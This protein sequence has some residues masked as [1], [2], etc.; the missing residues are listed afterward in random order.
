MNLAKEILLPIGSSQIEL[1]LSTNSVGEYRYTS[2]TQSFHFDGVDYK[3]VVTLSPLDPDTGDVATLPVERLSPA[4]R[5]TILDRANI[6]AALAA[7]KPRRMS[8][9]QR[10]AAEVAELQQQ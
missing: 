1:R 7:A 8:R 9:V 5:A 10:L 4:Q 6:A 2:G 3:Y